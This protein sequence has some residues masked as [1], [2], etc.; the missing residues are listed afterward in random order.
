VT[1]WLAGW[2]TATVTHYAEG[3]PEVRIVGGRMFQLRGWASV[4]RG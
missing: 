1:Y 2:D 4:L 3:S